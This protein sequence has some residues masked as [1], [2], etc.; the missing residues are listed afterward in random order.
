LEELLGIFPNGQDKYE[1]VMNYLWDVAKTNLL[2]ATNDMGRAEAATMGCLIG[3]ERLVNC[4][5]AVAVYQ[6][7]RKKHFI[8]DIPQQTLKEFER[9]EEQEKI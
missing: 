6:E 5:I 7:C 3:N 8:D 9:F 2:L 4:T 1:R